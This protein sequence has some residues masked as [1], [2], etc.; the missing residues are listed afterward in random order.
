MI[1]WLGPMPEK[2]VII[3]WARKRDRAAARIY[4]AKHIIPE[5]IRWQVWE[6]DNFTCQHCGSRRYLAIDHIIAVSKGGAND[7]SNYQTLCRRCN[8]KKG[9]R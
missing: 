5:A 7:I 1:E 4:K 6:R 3:E 8:S 9:A 2:D